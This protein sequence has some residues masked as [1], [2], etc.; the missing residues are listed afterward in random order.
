MKSSTTKKSSVR[1]S[2]N[3]I[4]VA[5]RPGQILLRETELAYVLSV[6]VSRIRFWRLHGGGPR[7]VKLGK[8]KRS[9]VRY[10]VQD[11]DVFVEKYLRNGVLH[12]SDL[13]KD[14]PAP[15]GTKTDE[16]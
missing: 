6:P 3:A 13:M 16:Q 12:P 14:A 2:G 15:K 9:S 11:V 5:P 4:A 8:D 7:W 1:R 10:R